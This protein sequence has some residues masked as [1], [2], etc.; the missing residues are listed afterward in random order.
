[1]EHEKEK[2]RNISDAINKLSKITCKWVFVF[3]KI[4]IANIDTFFQ[5]NYLVEYNPLIKY[6][7]KY[8]RYM[9]DIY[10]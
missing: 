5:S 8:F 6:K 1:M 4:Y 3:Q 10:K 7:N 9:Y 2:I